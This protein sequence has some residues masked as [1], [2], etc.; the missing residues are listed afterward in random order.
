MTFPSGGPGYPQQGGAQPQQPAPGTGQFPQ[1]PPSTA[2]AIRPAV[3]TAL[4]VTLLGL[5]QYFL[6]FSDE[7]TPAEQNSIFFLVG[8]LLAACQALPRAP[9]VSPFA[10]LF[11]TL[12]A[13]ES[14]DLVIS[15]PSGG[16]IPGIITV[17]LILGILQMLVAIATVLLD[18]DVL[19]IS[20]AKPAM[21]PYGQPQFG[22]PQY[23]Q[24]Q[25]F[26]QPGQPQG[27]GSF[28][29]P[30]GQQATTYASQQG[31]FF[32]QQSPPS[33]PEGGQSQQSGGTGTPPGGFSQPS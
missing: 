4:G 14:L 20:A 24:P 5:V 12:G 25:Q 31:Q 17:I 21:S 33:S 29:P 13:L 3:L 26:G 19:K 23:G 27:P 6:G 10:A 1:G 11:S 8:G 9:R 7:A 30:S 16:S 28:Q 18:F 2:F 22:A 15:V 32:Q